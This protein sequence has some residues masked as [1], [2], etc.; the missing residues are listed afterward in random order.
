MRALARQNRFLRDE[1]VQRSPHTF[2]TR[3]PGLA[4][5]LEK[6]DKV[7]DR[8]V[9]VLLT[10]ESGTGKEVLARY[11]HFSGSRRDASFIGLNCAP[12]RRAFS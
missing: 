2:V 10:G 6:A 7:K 11:I 1:L 5:L 4:A 8:A 9:T 3:D 12:S